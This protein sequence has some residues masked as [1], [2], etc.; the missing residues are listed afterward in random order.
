MGFSLQRGQR[1]KNEPRFFFEFSSYHTFLLHLIRSRVRSQEQRLGHS[2]GALG[3]A[4]RAL[5]AEAARASRQL[6]DGAERQHVAAGQHH[7]WVVGGGAF[8]GDG[9]SEDGVE[10][11][12]GG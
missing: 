3:G 2:G 9:T 5:E 6:C 1:A 4:V 7:R 11:Q 10:A 8:L 12:L